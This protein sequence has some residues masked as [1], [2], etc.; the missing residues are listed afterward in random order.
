MYLWNVLEYACPGG[1]T[2]GFLLKGQG[3]GAK[4]IGKNDGKGL[5]MQKKQIHAFYKTLLA[6]LT[7]KG[8]LR[9]AGL[10]KKDCPFPAGAGTLA[11]RAG[12]CAAGGGFL[13]RRAGAL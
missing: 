11:G 12:R 4:I 5:P 13:R 9:K 10:K 7:E 1:K 3:H 2:K 8:F 6:A